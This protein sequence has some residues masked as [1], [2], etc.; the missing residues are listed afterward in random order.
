MDTQFGG[1]RSSHGK[2]TEALKQG[3]AQTEGQNGQKGERVGAFDEGAGTK[4]VITLVRRKTL[5]H[6]LRRGSD[7][8]MDEI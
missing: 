5:F 2:G 4:G 8:P 3:S 7:W 1:S 6:R